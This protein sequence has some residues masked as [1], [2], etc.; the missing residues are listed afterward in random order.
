MLLAIL[1]GMFTY[2]ETAPDPQ[3]KLDSAVPVLSSSPLRIATVDMMLLY[4]DFYQ[5]NLARQ[6]FNVDNARI[7]KDNND[8]LTSI[9]QVENDMR[10]LKQQTEDP[11]LSDQK[12]AQVY[13]DYNYKYQMGTQLDKERREY[14][15]RKKQALQE[16]TAT[17]MR[18][19][20]DEIRKLVEVR[21]KA[22]NY[23]YVIDKSG[24]STSRVPILLFSKDATDITALLLQEL[25]KNAP[26]DFSTTNSAPDLAPIIEIPDM[27]R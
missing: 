1:S 20:L 25:H 15:G 5:T 7:Q 26:A 8:K 3:P 9:R 2:G 18:A 24:V 14:V 12:K 13:K 22:E 23:D 10:L 21:A 6:E 19:I 27:K 17:R 4:D 11:S 16:K